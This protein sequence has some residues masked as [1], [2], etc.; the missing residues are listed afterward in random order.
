MNVAM[1]SPPL[2]A[3]VLLG[4]ATSA[5]RRHRRPA[6]NGQGNGNNGGGQLMVAHSIYLR[7]GTLTYGGGPDLTVNGNILVGN[8]AGKREL[9]E[10]VK[11][12]GCNLG[13]GH[14]GGGI[15]L[16]R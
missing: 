14:P 16:L 11:A 4:L 5:T 1:D 8:Y 10:T 13:R 3:S 9:R 6:S 12:Q 15:H 7:S 2:Y